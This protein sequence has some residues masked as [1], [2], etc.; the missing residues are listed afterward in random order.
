MPYEDLTPRYF[1]H[2][3][4]LIRPFPDFDFSFIKP[5]RRKAVDLLRLSEGNRVL[6]MGCGPG[7][8]FPYLVGSVGQAGQVVGVEISPEVII[9]AQRRVAKN[10]WKNVELIRASA[11]EARLVGTF[12]GLLMFAAADVYASEE[13]LKNIFPHVREGARIV[14]FGAK[15]S[16]DRLGKLM[17]PLLLYLV[18]TLGFPTTPR[19]EPEPWRILGRYVDKIEIEEY[20]LGLMF[21]A[22]GS[23]R[24]QRQ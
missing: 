6:D 13:A 4:R 17:N 2:T 8:C 3:A 21:I 1:R 15:T 22:S 19:P 16:T 10:G 24:A 20:A 7:G 9:N 18:S 5:V 14:A 11:A 12:D 23:A